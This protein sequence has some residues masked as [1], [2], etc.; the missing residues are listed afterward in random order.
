MPARWIVFDLDDTLFL[1][2]DY[3]ASGFEAVSRHVAQRF[4]LQG[5]LEAATSLFASGARGD[6]FDRA[7]A[8]I[9]HPDP[10]SVVPALVAVYRQHRPRISL[11]PDAEAVL[12]RLVG[13]G[14]SVISDGPLESQAAKV[15]AL[16]LHDRAWPVILTSALGVGFGKPHPRAF[17]EIQAVAAGRPLVYVGDNP[18]KDFL[19]PARLGWRTVRVRREGSLHE[20]EPSGSDVDVELASLE[21]LDQSL[22]RFESVC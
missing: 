1:E 11:L 10:Q 5:F 3:V 13:S 8:L 18:K 14:V 9:G 17:L 12:R 4:D 20:G 16:R 15:A 19:A 2:R 7:L 6:V 22:D 21:E